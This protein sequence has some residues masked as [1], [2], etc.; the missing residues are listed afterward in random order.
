MRFVIKQRLMFCATLVGLVC[1]VH[2]PALRAG[3]VWDDTALVLRDPL[4]RSWRLIPEG[5]QHFLFTD[6]TASNFYRPLQRVTYTFEYWAFAFQPA[7]YHVLNLVLHAAAAS[8][9]F[10]FLNALFS[11]FEIRGAKWIAFTAAAIWAVHPL[12]SAAVD[13]VAGR[14]DSLA[15]F[16]GFSALTIALRGGAGKK[17]LIQ[18]LSAVVLLLASA[19]SK[20]SGL[21]FTLLY[22][23]IVAVRRDRRAILGA[24]TAVAFVA[25]IY[26][27]LRSQSE[28]LPIP[29][30][31]PHA[32]LA[33][34]PIIAA[35]ALAQYALLTV[36]PVRLHVERD[37]ESHPS[38]M[39]EA[40]LT[41]N[42]WL[43]LQTAAGVVVFVGIVIWLCRARR[44]N[45]AVFALLFIAAATYLPCCGLFSLN[46][47]M[48]E[49]WVYLPSAFLIAAASLELTR[50][51][52]TKPLNKFAV[53][54]L[55]LWFGF[56][57]LRSFARAGD[58]LDER[59]FFERTIAA[60]GNSARMLINLGVL[61][62]NEGHL[63]RAQTLLR[64]AL[65]KD[66]EQ[67][68]ALLNL[69][70]VELKQRNFVPARNYLEHALGNPVSEARAQ[71]LLTILEHQ[72]DGKV[73]LLRL[74]MA[75][76]LA[77]AWPITRRYLNALAESG[78]TAQACSELISLLQTEWYRAESW[79]LLSEYL[80]KAGHSPEAARASELAHRFDVHLV[81]KAANGF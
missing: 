81:S 42:A 61:E 74:R 45:P 43:E 40:S 8:A 15:A 80:A 29:Q 59:T 16:F 47:T 34:R 79:Q 11:L 1:A 71:E 18:Q 26:Y 41:S 6:A 19:L 49:H 55:A 58:W 44:R 28:V 9:L 78:R 14:A 21:I 22:F 39:G 52:H 27:T 13:Y 70:T 66:P 24:L 25:V 65:V 73:D 23:G 17:L 72:E 63:E 69:A 20:E 64:E 10:T 33:A 3:F 77:N 31:H 48:A 4:I 51:M 32:P 68:L 57:C 60:G 30:F 56:L 5:F 36:A 67:P 54:A 35:R 50:F 76:R 46:A 75:A 2:A 12:H 53:T 7:G 37:V 62:L 38:G